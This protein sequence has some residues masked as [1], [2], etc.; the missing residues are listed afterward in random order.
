MILFP[1]PPICTINMYK[2]VDG[3]L[4]FYG[5]I[6]GVSLFNHNPPETGSGNYTQIKGNCLDRKGK[7][8][9][10]NISIPG[11]IDGIADKLTLVKFSSIVSCLFI[12]Q[13]SWWMKLVVL[14][15][16]FHWLG[17]AAWEAKGESMAPKESDGFSLFHN[18]GEFNGLLVLVNG[19]YTAYRDCIKPLYC[20]G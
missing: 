14:N 12:N 5:H 7:T 20:F 19:I 16:Y 17:H 18:L 10:N 9:Q 1:N 15:I 4:T 2:K 13:M 3:E 11:T 6:L 8:K